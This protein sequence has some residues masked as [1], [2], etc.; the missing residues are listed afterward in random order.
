[1]KLYMKVYIVVVFILSLT[2]VSLTFNIKYFRLCIVYHV[3]GQAQVSIST[4]AQSKRVWLNK[5][6]YKTG[7]DYKIPVLQD[8]LTSLLRF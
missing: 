8:G 3:D 6:F 4:S 1:M 2:I 7:V 5:G